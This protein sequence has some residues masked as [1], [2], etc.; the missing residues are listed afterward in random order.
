MIGIFLDDVPALFL[1]MKTAH[2]ELVGDRG[3]TLIV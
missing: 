3:I 2:T 1:C